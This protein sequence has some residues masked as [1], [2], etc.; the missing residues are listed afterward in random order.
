MQKLFGSLTLAC[1]LALG[2]SGAGEMKARADS[3]SVDDQLACTPDVFRLCASEIPFEDR[4][5][6][7]LNS[8]KASLSPECRNVMNGTSDEPRRKK[9]AS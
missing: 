9:R 4:I 5:V 2:L 1:C 8:K 3:G 6:Q 7:C